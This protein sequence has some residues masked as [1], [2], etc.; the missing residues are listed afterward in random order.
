[1]YVLSSLFDNTLEVVSKPH[2]VPDG[3][4]AQRTEMLTYFVY[5]PLSIRWDALRVFSQTQPGV[6]KLLQ[7]IVTDGKKIEPFFEC[8]FSY[9][10][11]LT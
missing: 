8:S 2:L 10:F 11:H 9:G 1:M 7:V 4:V 3:C 6:L 5:A